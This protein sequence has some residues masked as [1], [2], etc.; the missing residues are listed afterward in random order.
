MQ[1]KEN[2]H[3]LLDMGTNI[4]TEDEEKVE[5]VKDFFASAFNGKTS[6]SLGTRPPKLE[7]KC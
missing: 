2:L 7:D 6:C 4:V 3:P 5:V 1:Q